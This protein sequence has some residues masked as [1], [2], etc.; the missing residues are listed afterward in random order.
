MVRNIKLILDKENGNVLVD[1]KMM[2]YDL[3]YELTEDVIDA[4]KQIAIE[5]ENFEEVPDLM[6]YYSEIFD[7][8]NNLGSD[9]EIVEL[10]E[11][12]L[13]LTPKE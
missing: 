6:E 9:P 7:S 13:S 3:L 12:L 1:D 11:Q 8:I 4:E 5:F 2:D 10:K